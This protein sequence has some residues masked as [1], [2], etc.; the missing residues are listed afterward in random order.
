M[1]SKMVDVPPIVQ[2]KYPEE[3]VIHGCLELARN[4]N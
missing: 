1:A 4:Y 2:A 3:A